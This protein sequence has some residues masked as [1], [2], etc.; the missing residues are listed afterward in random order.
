MVLIYRK[1]YCLW[2]Q[3]N[4]RWSSHAYNP[5]QSVPCVLIS[6]TPLCWIHLWFPRSEALQWSCFDVFLQHLHSHV[7]AAP[8]SQRVSHSASVVDW[9]NKRCFRVP[10]DGN[11]D[12]S[13]KKL[14]Q[15]PRVLV[16]PSGPEGSRSSIVYC[17]YFLY[18]NVNFPFC[19]LVKW[20]IGKIAV[21]FI[22]QWLRA[23]TGFKNRQERNKMNFK[24]LK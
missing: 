4:V 24:P 1:L 13:L 8:V 2:W 23:K 19:N 15:P 9:I 14:R 11:T 6:P 5:E 21:S 18:L 16:L 10:P 12:L 22:F 7:I 17:T 20:S 3:E